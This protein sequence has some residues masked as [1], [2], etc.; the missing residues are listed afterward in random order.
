M[1]YFR[2]FYF[3]FF[4]FYFNFYQAQ[5]DLV[6]H[7]SQ[8]VDKPIPIMF[9]P[10]SLNSSSYKSSVLPNGLVSVIK[11]DLSNT[12]QF[13]IINPAGVFAQ[14]ILIN[15]FPWSSWSSSQIQADYAVI[16]A[17]KPEDSGANYFN[18]SFQLYNTYGHYAVAGKVYNH[19]PKAQLRLLAHQI[20]NQIY[21]TITGTP[22]DF[23]SR[24]AYVTVDNPV[25]RSAL[26][27]LIVSDQDGFNPQVLL[28]QRGN[29]IASP[30]WS[31]DQQ[32][33]AYVSYKNNRMAVYQIKLSTGERTLI[34]HFPGIN[35]AP[36]YSPNGQYMALALSM[37]QGSNTD[38]YLIDLNSKKYQK[39]TNTG[40]NTE[41]S[42]SPDNQSIVFTSDRAGNKPQVYQINLSNLNISRLSFEGAQN[43]KPE[44]TPDGKNIVLMHQEDLGGP[45]QIAVLNLASG[46]MTEIT[47]GNL[48]KSPSLSPNGRMVI[49]ANYDR[50]K[51]V[52]A[53]ASMNGQVQLTLPSSAGWV[54]SPAW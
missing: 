17:I 49:Y 26:Y 7:I 48:D 23:N 46:N 44:Y 20:A 32:Y 15:Q 37:D 24:I 38:I 14:P 47:H 33:L 13:K 1:K 36:A 9:S 11:N 28:R 2:N 8:G 52:L 18:V 21:Q 10:M 12:G 5:A 45:I 16:G 39:L 42:F 54:Q 30:T 53:E 41:P 29:P 43:F 31:K 35:S 40:A 27:Q 3:L 6:V 4:I 19:I 51:G 22:G 50:T 25:A 34:S